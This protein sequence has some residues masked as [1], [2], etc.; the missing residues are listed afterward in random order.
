MEFSK[1]SNPYIAR[2]LR[3]VSAAYEVKGEDYFRIR[4]YDNAAD[5][6]EHATSEIKDLWESSQLQSIPGI[7]GSI[8]GH[9]D[10]YFRTG[11]VKHFKE[12]KKGLPP[13]MFEFLGLEGVGPKT[14]YR[15]AKELKLKTLGDLKKAASSSKVASLPGFKEKSA[16]QILK[17]IEEYKEG[18]GR[19]ILP[20]AYATA[21]KLIGKIMDMPGVKRADPMGSLRRMVSTIGDIDIGISTTEPKKV[22]EVFT[23]LPDVARVLAA[24]KAKATVLLKT[25]K[26]V[27]IYAFDPKSYGSFIQYFTGSKQHNIHLRKVANDMGYSLSEH[28]VRKFK[29]GKIFG[30]PL[31]VANEEKFYKMLGMDWIPPEIREDTGEIE[32]ALE[33]KLPGLIEFKDIKGDTHTHTTNSDG[34]ETAEEMVQAAIDRRLEYYGISDHAPSVQSLGVKGAREVLL[35]WKEEVEKLRK[36]YKGEIELFFSGEI[37]ITAAAEV[38]LP[39]ELMALYDYTTASIHSSFNQSKEKMTERI[40]NALKN[41]YVDVIGHPTGRLLG[42]RE[43]YE[44]DWNRVFDVAVEEGKFLEINAFPTRLD[45]PDSLVRVAK[46][47]GVRFMINT[48]AHHSSHLDNMRFGAAVAR[49]GWCEKTDIINTFGAK[50]FAKV[51]GIGRR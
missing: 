29:K 48:D 17:A 22:V 20:I 44:V 13:G 19:M 14:A 7:G 2:M 15:L 16:K 50:E 46:R 1:L 3:E 36:K 41:P 39:D 23:N 37:D 9:L 25:G 6:V 11:K 5:A 27:D 45:L 42:K 33:G 30:K 21:E 43:A 35:K 38:E 10:E 31:P 8:A 34:E 26:Q 47:K 51:M 12:A 4:A 49:R 28:G 18:E 40:V 32:A 24:G